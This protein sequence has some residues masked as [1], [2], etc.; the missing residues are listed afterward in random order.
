MSSRLKSRFTYVVRSCGAAEPARV[1]L[2]TADELVLLD[3]ED[4]GEVEITRLDGQADGPR[5]V[6]DEVVVLVH[7]V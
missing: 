5:R 4:V 1:E 6:V 7:G 3:I 2:A